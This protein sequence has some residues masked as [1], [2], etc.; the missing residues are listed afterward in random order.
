M[1]RREIAVYRASGNR[2][3]TPEAEIADLQQTRRRD[4]A[5]RR[6]KFRLGA[7]MRYDD[8]STRRDRALIPLTRKTF[9]DG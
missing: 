4:R 1:K 2:G 8:A 9:G 7:R 5:R 6:I 3:N